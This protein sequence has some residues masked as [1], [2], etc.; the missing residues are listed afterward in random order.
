[1]AYRQEVWMR[2]KRI[3]WLAVLVNLNALS[4]EV[5]M[6]VVD[7]ILKHVW[8]NLVVAEIMIDS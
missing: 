2:Q 8:Y 3:S 4:K 5:Q 1:M 7:D 6:K